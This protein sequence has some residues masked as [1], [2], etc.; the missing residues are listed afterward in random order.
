MNSPNCVDNI[1]GYITNMQSYNYQIYIYM[2]IKDILESPL[3][4]KLGKSQH[5]YCKTSPKTG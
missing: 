5:I 4:N 2:L 3:E 1:D